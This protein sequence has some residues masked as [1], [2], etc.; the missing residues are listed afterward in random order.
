MS[1]LPPPPRI[2]EVADVDFARFHE[3]IRPAREPVIMRG[4]VSDW[5]AVAVAKEGDNA[6]VDYLTRRTPTRPVAAIAAPPEAR[7]RFFYNRDLTGFNFRQG[8]G[9]LEDFLAD[10][11]RA[12]SMS[13]PP[14]M[15]VQ[16]ETISSVMP[17][18]AEANRLALL[19]GVE[20]R[21]WIGNRI[22]VA[23]HYD[24]K[25]NV[26]CCV[27]GRRRFTLFP[28][29]QLANLYAGPFELTPAGTPVSMVDP[30]DPDLER[31]PRFASAWATARTATLQPG[32][33]LYIPYTW[34][35]GVESLEPVSILVNYWWND[36]PEGVAPAY[37]ALLHAIYAY[38]HLPAG[39]RDVWRMMLDHYVFEAN[40]DPAAHLPDHAKGILGPPEPRFFAHMK[41]MLRQIIG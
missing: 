31:Y 19:P 3:E 23:P 27:A 10:L 34:W 21:I 29:E 2:R 9:R 1:E 20:A 24:I 39:D 22:R 41:A 6:I 14:A 5:P 38:R 4:L 37:D 8:Q 13:D 30:H 17:T 25:E 32:D 26:A 11:L 15:A 36:A 16:S 35:H 33:A 7:G 40:G 28:P 12:K 18:F